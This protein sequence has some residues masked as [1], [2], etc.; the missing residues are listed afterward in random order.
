MLD[1]MKMCVH[2]KIGM[3][4]HSLRLTLKHLLASDVSSLT[5]HLVDISDLISYLVAL[6]NCDS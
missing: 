3:N 2:A 5:C 1:L 6:D 4:T